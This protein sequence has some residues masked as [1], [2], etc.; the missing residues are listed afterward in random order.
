[1]PAIPPPTLI[2]TPG[3]MSA[4]GLRADPRCRCPVPCRPGR[5]PGAAAG[6]LPAPGSAGPA[7]RH[8]P[9]TTPRPAATRGTLSK[10]SRL[11][12]IRVRTGPIEDLSQGVRTADGLEADHDRRPLELQQGRQVVRGPNARVDPEVEIQLRELAIEC[13]RREAS[14][15]MASRSATYNS[16]EAENI[17]VGPGQCQRIGRG[18]QE[19]SNRLIMRA[20]ASDGVDGSACLDVENRD[21][22]KV[23][24]PH[25]F[26]WLHHNPGSRMGDRR[27]PGRPRDPAVL[28]GRGT[29]DP[30]RRRGRFRRGPGSAVR[31]DHDAR[32]A[33]VRRSRSLDDRSDRRGRRGPAV[34][35][36][37][38]GRRIIPC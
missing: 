17:A 22:A 23:A 8:P 15:E 20:I 19:A 28:G 2:S 27:R 5:D 29:G 25:G 12:T 37:W 30:A 16:R 14:P 9:T 1:M 6:A 4:N 7:L 36:S 21:H 24:H 13:I 26:P 32:R 10:R 33:M 38:P 34:S 11:R 18:M 31:G 35:S 3:S